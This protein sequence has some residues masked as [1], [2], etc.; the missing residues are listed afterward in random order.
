[1]M[2]VVVVMMMMCACLRLYVHEYQHPESP[3]GVISPGP[4]VTDGY[5]APEGGAGY[6]VQVLCKV[7][8]TTEP[9]LQPHKIAW[10]RKRR[11]ISSPAHAP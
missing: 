8:L 6:Q 5:G 9:L 2:M 1:M 7:L 10:G 4:G 3:E 11:I